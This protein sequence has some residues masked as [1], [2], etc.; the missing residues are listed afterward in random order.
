MDNTPQRDWFLVTCAGIEALYVLQYEHGQQGWN[1]ISY[2]LLLETYRPD[3]FVPIRKRLEPG[4]LAYRQPPILRWMDQHVLPKIAQDFR[5]HMPFQPM[6][7]AGMTPR[8]ILVILQQPP[9]YGFPIVATTN[10]PIPLDDQF[11]ATCYEVP[12]NDTTIAHAAPHQ[13]LVLRQAVVSTI[14]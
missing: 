12:L 5:W 4:R 8:H 6:V 7:N 11:R 14:R 1:S 9:W 2:L 13:L 3:E 10:M